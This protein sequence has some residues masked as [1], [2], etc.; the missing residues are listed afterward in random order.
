MINPN[1]VPLVPTPC[2][3]IPVGPLAPDAGSTCTVEIDGIVET[4]EVDELLELRAG[5]RMHHCIGAHGVRVEAVL[6][7]LHAVE[8]TQDNK[9]HV[10]GQTLLPDKGVANVSD[11]PGHEAL[12]IFEL[13][14][15]HR[16]PVGHI[17]V[18]DTHTADHALDEARLRFERVLLGT[19]QVGDD[20][21]DIVRFIFG[22]IVGITVGNTVDDDVGL[23]V[24]DAF[25]HTVGII[26]GLIVGDTVSEA[27]SAMTLEILSESLL[28][29]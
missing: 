1:A 24:G 29:S 6:V 19:G 5:R 11:E 7:A 27:P 4:R 12:P 28:G 20:V 13:V 25:G 8:V 18:A 9:W 15:I 2:P 23:T 26:V 14:A 10:T 3:I 16:V 21:G 22:L 17:H